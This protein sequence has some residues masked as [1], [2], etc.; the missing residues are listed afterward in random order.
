SLK[1]RFLKQNNL[2]R[3]SH[4]SKENMERV[5]ALFSGMFDGRPNED[6][7]LE[8]PGRA[9]E[10]AVA[11]RDGADLKK[12]LSLRTFYRYRKELLKYNIDIA[13]RC[14]VQ[15]LPTKVN[16]INVAPLTMPDWYH[17]PPVDV[18][19]FKPVEEQKLVLVLPK[20][21]A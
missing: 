5:Y 19:E 9:G 2:W 10:L 11:W 17:L 1:S 21:A 4:W 14:N 6:A 12:R 8:I 3:F 7:F 15:R 20:R 18:V 16:V 13:V